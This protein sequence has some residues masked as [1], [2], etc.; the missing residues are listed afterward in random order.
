[1]NFTRES[2]FISAIRK[3]C[4]TFAVILG[5][6]VAIFVVLLGVG[7]MS[8][9]INTPS[10][11]DLTVS[12]DA[13][14]NRKLL[15]D[16]TPVLLKIKMEGVIGTL[17]LRSEK[18]KNMLLDSREGSLAG[19][20]VKGIFIHMNTPGGVA[21]DGTNIYALF[22]EYKEKYKVPIYVYVDGMCASAGIYISAAADQV[23]ASADSI[24]GSVGVRLGPL[25]NFSE[26]LG[27]IG[28]TPLTLTEGK[29]KDALNPTRP[30]TEGE[31][32][33]IQKIMA[34]NYEE[35]VN[36]VTSAR[37]GLDKDKLVHEYG[38]K[39]FTSAEGAELGY[40]DRAGVS[41]NEALAALA[42]AANVEESYQVLE[43]SPAHNFFQ[44]LSENKFQL[45]QGKFEPVLPLGPYM[46][47]EMSG[48]IL[49]LYQP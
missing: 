31:S 48:K 34:A 25:Y 21:I 14:W 38:A 4:N 45:L 19:D 47:T 16:T 37:K 7:A 41:Y 3:F 35:F 18:I 20:R 23:Y 2:I 43:I 42:K 17:D 39:V 33:P 29:G 44:D 30:W 1:M 46:T 36:V 10:K 8:N 5:V 24:V 12:P 15:A 9:S 27:K 40:I 26:T 49:F 32:A 11:G 22:K 13:N 6:S 28:V